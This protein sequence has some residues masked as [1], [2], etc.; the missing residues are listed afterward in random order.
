[1]RG[2]DPGPWPARRNPDVVTN[3]SGWMSRSESSSGSSSGS[4]WVVVSSIPQRVGGS[5]RHRVA[6]RLRQTG[7]VT[8]PRLV[9]ASSSP[10]RR[11]ILDR[12]ELHYDVEPADLDERAHPGEEPRAYVERLAREKAEARS[13]PDTVA[14]GCDTAV[15]LDGEI[16]GKPR[17]PAHAAEMLTR[18][19]DRTHEAIT[20]VAVVRRTGTGPPGIHT[21]TSTTTVHFGPLPAERI[22]WYLD[23]GE[24]DDK[25]GAYGIQGAAALFADHIEG[26]TTNVMGLPLPL[27]D[28]LC[29]DAGIDLLSFRSGS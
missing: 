23:T 17:D 21:G 5:D 19:A 25:A 13:G 16:L 8:R 2:S 4:S 20:G 18:M 6:R 28:R 14:I 3:G 12:L 22:A 29:A 10:R 15:V 27:L 26:S 11:D 9:L 7:A 24:P 1:M